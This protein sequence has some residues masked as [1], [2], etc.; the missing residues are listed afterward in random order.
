MCSRRDFLSAGFRGASLIALSPSVPA[1]LAVTAEAAPPEPDA[2]VLVVIQLDGGN[3]GINTVVP[4]GDEG[5]ARHRELLRLHA[6]RLIKVAAGIGLHPSLND[7]VKLLESGWLAVVPGVGYPNP[8][9]SHFRSMAVWQTARLDP[10]EHQGPGWIGRIGDEVPSAGAIFLG[11]ETP[12]AALRGRRSI[13]A[14]VDRLAD[15]TLPASIDVKPAAASSSP[16][17]ELSSFV[18]RS[19]LDAYATAD[20]LAEMTRGRKSGQPEDGLFGHLLT[21]A[22]LI[23]SGARARIYYAQ[24]GGYDTH[25]QQLY[26]HSAL[27]RDLGYALKAF[28]EELTEAKLADRVVVL[29]FSEFGRRV[30]EN[31]S[32]GT[33]HGT[34]G[35][36]LLAGPAVQPGLIGAYPSLTDLEGGDLKM[37]VDF[38]RVYAAAVEKWLELPSARALGGSFTPLPL[39][40]T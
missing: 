16:E 12:P 37:T 23:K 13:P 24:H 5:Y 22:R 26:P 36:V 35:P 17:N 38:R 40:R 15:F 8:S 20:R 19:L 34:S 11:S 28:F 4:C 39:F 33:D 21:V 32:G 3:D 29:C 31:A 6:D 14:S 27:L 2:R 25:A 9:R 30:Q 1:F 7:V 10:E 18:E